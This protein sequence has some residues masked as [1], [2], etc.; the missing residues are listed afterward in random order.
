M[1]RGT[2]EYGN[3]GR[4]FTN[5]EIIMTDKEKIEVLEKCFNDVIWMS[6]RY[7]HGRHTYAPH[8][9]RRAVESFKKVFPDWKP[10]E[11]QT[12]K[13]PED[14][15]IIDIRSDINDYLNDLFL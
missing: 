3:N 9:V 1:A 12:I 13:E 4:S 14:E 8:M 5:T 7:A 10:K 2:P 11:D 15:E 6:I